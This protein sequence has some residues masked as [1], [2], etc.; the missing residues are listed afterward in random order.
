MCT[1]YKKSVIIINTMYNYLKKIY[2]QFKNQFKN[3]INISVKAFSIVEIFIYI[4]VS[5]IVIVAGKNI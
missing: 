2:N 5:C 3:L 4:G 1:L